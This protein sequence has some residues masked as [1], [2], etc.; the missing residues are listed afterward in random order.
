MVIASDCAVRNVVG[1][2]PY[3][4]VLLQSQ[5]VC[6]LS[7][8]SRSGNPGRRGMGPTQLKRHL[9]KQAELLNEARKILEKE[10]EVLQVSAAVILPH[11]RGQEIA[12]ATSKQHECVL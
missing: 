9:E 3:L 2:T 10:L 6:V 1:C 12:L 5:C 7:M 4:E 8:C 11:E